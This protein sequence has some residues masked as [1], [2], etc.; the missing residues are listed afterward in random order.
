MMHILLSNRN[1]K[2][3]FCE[4]LTF[5]FHA[6]YKRELTFYKVKIF[7]RQ[8]FCIVMIINMIFVNVF[9]IHQLL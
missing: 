8:Y 3:P 7:D 2:L 1:E 6:K 5:S 9:Q 4:L